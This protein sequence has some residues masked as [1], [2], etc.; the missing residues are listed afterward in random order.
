MDSSFEHLY[1][2]FWLLAILTTVLNTVIIW[3]K[4]RPYVKQ[5]PELAPGYNTL[6]K[7]FFF[8]S[9]VPW[10]VMGTGLLFGNVPSIEAFFEPQWQNSFVMAWWGTMALLYSL[11]TYWILWNGGAEMLVK[12]PGFLRGNLK[13]PKIIKLVWLLSLAGGVA[14]SVIIL[15]FRL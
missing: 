8:W 3:F 12:H 11:G 2:Y 14:A 9:N 4:T 10:V 1:N 5:K 7:G 6:L 15:S 13:N